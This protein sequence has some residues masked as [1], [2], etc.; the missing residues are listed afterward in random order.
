[1]NIFTRAVIAALLAISLTLGVATSAGAHGGHGHFGVSN[2]K[3]N[4]GFL[5]DVTSS[6]SETGLKRGSKSAQERD[7][8]GATDLHN[9]ADGF[10]VSGAQL[11]REALEGAR[12]RRVAARKRKAAAKLAGLTVLSDQQVR[13]RVLMDTLGL[14]VTTNADG[15]AS[16]TTDVSPETGLPV[17]TPVEN[18]RS[19][20]A[21]GAL[22]DGPTAL[23]PQVGGEWGA[24]V[25]PTY[26][27]RDA[28]LANG[29]VGDPIV[30]VDQP[31]YYDPANPTTDN[32]RGWSPNPRIVPVF[33]ALMP[34]G[35]V[36]YWDWLVSGVMDNSAEH[37]DYPSTRILL[38]DP[39]NPTAP[40]ERLDVIGANLF[41]A[42]FSHLPNGD[43]LVAGGN[44]GQEMAGLEHTW[45]YSWRN[46]TWTRSQD[47]E[48]PRWYPSVASLANGESLIIAGDPQDENPA[49]PYNLPGKAYPEVFTSNYT[50]PAT[51]AWDP[52]N[53]ADHIRGLTNLAYAPG[54]PT[55]PS[56]RIYPFVFPSLDG[57]VLYA[58]A[59]PNMQLI[60]T[61]GAGSY[62]SYGPRV[63]SDQWGNGIVREYGSAANFDRGRT[64]VNGGGKPARYTFEPN[65]PTVP[66]GDPN[67][68]LLANGSIAPVNQR[69]ECVG[70]N[71]VI[72]ENEHGATDTS[73]LIDTAGEDRPNDQQGLPASTAAAEMNFRRRMHQLTVLPD[74]KVLATGGLSDTDPAADPSYDANV[75][76]LAN[77]LVNPEAA[78]YAA[79]VWDPETDEWTLLDSATKI[80]QYHS[81]AM[82][83]PDGR[84]ISG[85]GGVCGP[86]YHNNY[87]E[88]NFEFFSPPYLFN[89][90]GSPRS[91][92][93]RPRITEPTIT[94][95]SAQVLEPVEYTDT[96]NVDYALGDP[97]SSIEQVSLIKLAA[98][99]HGT[100]QGT[101]RAPLKFD[102]S[103]PGTLE[104]TAP[105]NAFEASPGFYM[106][107]LVDSG[108]VPSV[109]KM[110]QVGAQLPL[111]NKLNATVGYENANRTGDSQDFG[112]G[113]FSAKRG[114]LTPVGDNTI[115]SMTVAAGYH[116]SVCRGEEFTDCVDV[117]AGNYDQIGKRFSG[118]ISSITVEAGTI[119]AT[120]PEF[121]DVTADTAP[122]V[123]VVNNP[124]DDSTQAGTSAT[125]DFTV[126]DVVDEAPTCN[127]DDGEVL[128]LQNG[129]NTITINCVDDSSNA[130]NFI[131]NIYVGA[132]DDP[133]TVTINSPAN[134]SFTTA[135]SASIAFTKAGTSPVNCT[136]NGNAVTSP[137]TVALAIGANPITVN[138]A[139]GV[140]SDS[141]TVTI[142]RGV[143]P[144][145]E[146]SSPVS[147]GFTT[148]AT[149]P[150]AF[151]ATGNAPVACTING[152]TVTSPATVAVVEGANTITVTCT[153][154]YGSATDSVVV[155]RG[156]AA[157][158]DITFPPDGITTTLAAGNV[159]FNAAGT[160]PVVCTL[161]GDVAVSPTPIALAVGANLVTV[162]C[163]NDY[164]SETEEVTVTRGVAPTVEITSP[165]GGAFTTGATVPVAFTTTGTG[166]ITCSAG[167][168]AVTSPATVALVTGSNTILVTCSSIYGTASDTVI[169]NRGTAPTVQI[170]SPANGYATPSDSVAV[171]FSATGTGPVAC[172][173]NGATATSP[174][175]VNLLE[176]SNSIQVSCSNA[177]GTDSKS[178][179]V[180]S[181]N[182]ATV[183]ITSLD[184]IEFTT[185]ASVAVEF[186]ASG[187]PPV[188]CTMGGNPVT[189][190][191]T[192]PVAEGANT[193][194]VTCTDL[195]GS[196]TDSVTVNRGT[197]ATVDI[198]FP[199]DGVFTTLAEGDV[200]FNAVGTAPVACTLNGDSATSPVTLPLSVG[201]NSVSVT[202]T[203][204]YGSETKAITINRGVAPGVVITAPDGGE[205]TSGSSIAVEFTPTG[206]EPVECKV[207]GDTVTSPATV[208]LDPGANT[209]VVTCTND[210]GSASD[211]V[212]VDRGAAPVVEITSPADGSSTAE[213]VST[214][215]FTATGTAPVACTLNGNA[216]DGPTTIA[217]A[218]G[219][220]QVV[221]N[222]SND[223]GSDSD[224]ITINRGNA[225][226][227]QVTSPINGYSTT[228]S[229][230]SVAFTSAGPAP[231]SCTVNGVAATSP[232][233]VALSVG[234]NSI[235]VS[236]SSV[237]GAN[238][239][240]ILVNR[241]S[242]E[243]PP[244]DVGKPQPEKFSL[245]VPKR[246]KVSQ[247]LYAKVKCTDGCWI[248]M[249]ITTGKKR[250][251]VKTQWLNASAKTRRVK[252]R[253]SKTLRTRVKSARR[254]KIRVLYKATIQTNTESRASAAG[255]YR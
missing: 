161:N 165:E 143:Q 50:S 14:P 206:T 192:V 160:A 141:D 188:S 77:E 107:F 185:A 44:L 138:C 255:R 152:A 133:A 64:L 233:T 218:N 127:Y 66:T 22:R 110:I 95:G 9:Y 228:E 25:Q 71:T 186:S 223:Y 168:G 253:L 35:K 87:S 75:G 247:M 222:C 249:Q 40:G 58:G 216:A 31:F 167:G 176:G 53:P 193:I 82:L 120:D 4:G 153:D 134:G 199:E 19:A 132:V 139:N 129:P 215:Q 46:K 60:D 246:L 106:L 243:P 149:L 205:L 238:S 173:V 65:Q 86:C 34:D 201:A 122:P 36:L 51:Q 172:T 126:T 108:G 96:F 80:R 115:K 217:L 147:G 232:T 118:R 41:C 43:L 234:A 47:M 15:F 191:V 5:N 178:I 73:A 13:E 102:D 214:V 171:Q 49:S 26:A 244:G 119:A 101:M 104:I 116:A 219:A 196:A 12:E 89:S 90:D 137:A 212:I 88:A 252:F 239:V 208:A 83:I 154:V 166:P 79:E 181:G 1:M 33:S 148:G 210:Y 8:S 97:G 20:R 189:S 183:T 24:P 159:H 190:P 111:A 45:V 194:S 146:I 11:R 39:A 105:E 248:R 157:S 48:R 128:N 225:A 52:A 221:V 179:T 37:N 169:V 227:V 131:L 21:L 113:D 27:T 62:S 98:P 162:T 177:Y 140:A 17:E 204:D 240:L 100:D 74:G 76:N 18:Q 202:C 174:A 170:T 182:V 7:G 198:T 213:F 230:T 42:G 55:P 207:D 235:L 93:Q 124:V 30:D 67:D 85:G 130:A 68:C 121:L 236:C 211:S 242:T 78:V 195:Y 81:T 197:A 251:N 200:H 241:T 112:L 254:N 2:V 72:E 142:N 187:T 57:R 56:W 123:I 150:V 109:A 94:D 209:I 59:E 231:V 151:T 69:Q 70:T 163:S 29:F 237:Y 61:R 136:I 63:D 184:D 224:T 145:V 38:W 99:T 245:T 28:D 155:N 158:V 6:V 220:N 226:T 23:A 229:S 103:T 84:V 91:A 92:T 32:A 144:T 180:N 16:A 203:N 125:L 135:A 250:A 164:G 175:T 117:K 10:G 3:V 114:H 54:D 156:T